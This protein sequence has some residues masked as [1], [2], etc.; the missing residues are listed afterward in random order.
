MRQMTAALLNVFRKKAPFF[1]YH[2]MFGGCIL[3]K[4]IHFSL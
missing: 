2:T 1:E 4:L 3:V